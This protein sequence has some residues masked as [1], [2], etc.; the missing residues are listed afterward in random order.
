MILDSD[1]FWTILEQLWLLK[2]NWKHEVWKS[3]RNAV[4]ASWREEKVM[5]YL[6]IDFF[7]IEDERLLI[8]FHIYKTRIS[9]R[10]Q[11][12]IVFLFSI[13]NCYTVCQSH[14]AQNNS[15]IYTCT[16]WC[17]QLGRICTFL[18]S[19][20]LIQNTSRLTVN[21]D[22]E[23]GSTAT[24]ITI[25]CP[26]TSYCTTQEEHE[27]ASKTIKIQQRS[28]RTTTFAIGV[29]LERLRM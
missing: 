28:K 7:S 9:A 13:Q 8:I 3:E 11:V 26:S 15:P 18:G 27:R 10:Y 20:Y 23:T 25:S 22:I 1:E 14:V 5:R 21:Q 16:I 29:Q 4:V 6:A 19:K 12:L 2:E 24:S 17:S